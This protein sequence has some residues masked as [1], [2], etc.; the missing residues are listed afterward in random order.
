[1]APMRA[2]LMTLLK[3]KAVTPTR[4]IDYKNNARRFICGR[5]CDWFVLYIFY[6]VM[7]LS[8]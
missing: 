1:M 8:D 4:I 7:L 6:A 3:I 5:F 2:V